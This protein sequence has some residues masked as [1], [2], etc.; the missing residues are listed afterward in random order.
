VGRAYPATGTNYTC[1]D[2]RSCY[3]ASTHDGSAGCTAARTDD[4][5]AVHRAAAPHHDLDDGIILLELVSKRIAG[6]GNES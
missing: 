3:C 4:R 5:G 2:T 1:T 6:T